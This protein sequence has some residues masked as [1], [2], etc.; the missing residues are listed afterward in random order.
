MV[1]PS[2]DVGMQCILINH[3]GES[4]GHIFIVQVPSNGYIQHLKEN[5]KAMN[6][7]ILDSIPALSLCLWKL[8][9]PTDIQELQSKKDLMAFLKEIG[10]HCLDEDSELENEPAKLLENDIEISQLGQL[11]ITKLH[12]IVQMSGVYSSVLFTHCLADVLSLSLIPFIP[13]SCQTSLM[14][15]SKSFPCQVI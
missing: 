7:D 15:K 14:E 6:P 13:I 2:A 5:I 11:S 10:Q 4:T 3:Q 9:N 12:V 8:H 1:A